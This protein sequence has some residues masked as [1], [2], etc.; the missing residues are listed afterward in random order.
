M[1]FKFIQRNKSK[2][3]WKQKQKPPTIL[4]GTKN[5]LRYKHCLTLT[6]CGLSLQGL[7]Q[8]LLLLLGNQATF[9]I[10]DLFLRP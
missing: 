10:L 5:L 8:E 2:Q 4:M 3:N 1:F 9:T 6:G 7:R